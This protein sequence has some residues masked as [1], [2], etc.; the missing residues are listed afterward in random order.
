MVW[1][2]DERRIWAE[3]FILRSVELHFNEEQSGVVVRTKVHEVC[4][5]KTMFSASFR[6]PF[7]WVV[8]ELLSHLNLAHTKSYPMPRG[9][10]TPA[11]CFGPWLSKSGISSPSESSSGCIDSRR[12]PK[13]MVCT[14]SSLGGESLSRWKASTLVTLGGRR[15]TFSLRTNG[16]S[17]LMMLWKVI[18][19]ETR[20]P[21]AHASKVP[22]LTEAELAWVNKIL[23]WAQKHEDLMGYSN[24]ITAAY[25]KPFK[26]PVPSL[27]PPAAN[28]RR[29]T[30]KSPQ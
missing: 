26:R 23:A 12:T 20:A 25:K 18:P 16:N 29:A 3:C 9:C 17:F 14:T 8:Q 22:R 4:L 5:Y 13:V 7:Q 11:F 15:S 30:P 21:S 10:S 2:A 24:L 19:R 1:W 28:T 27:T 6:L